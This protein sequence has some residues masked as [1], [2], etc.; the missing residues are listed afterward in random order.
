MDSNGFPFNT[1]HLVLNAFEHRVLKDVQWCWTSLI[2][3]N[4]SYTK[5]VSSNVG[6]C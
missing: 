1:L 6:R 4:H 5:V 2:A 3:G